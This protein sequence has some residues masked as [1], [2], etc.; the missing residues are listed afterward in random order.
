MQPGSVMA[1]LANLVCVMREELRDGRRFSLPGFATVSR[2]SR[3][4]T[5]SIVLAKSFERDMGS[6]V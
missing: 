5:V 2:N 6:L 3:N 1:V 4:N